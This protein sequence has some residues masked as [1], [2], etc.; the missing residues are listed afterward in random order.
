MVWLEG[1]RH[2]RPAVN[3]HRLVACP[4]CLA[5][6][7]ET[8]KTPSGQVTAEHG[9]R[10]VSRVC[11]CG[12]PVKPRHHYCDTCGPRALQVSKNDH[13]R[14]RRQAAGARYA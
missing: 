3:V 5:R 4:T 6:M 11:S 14:R 8:C 12:G 7:D 2:P 9:S 13:G 10:L 1:E